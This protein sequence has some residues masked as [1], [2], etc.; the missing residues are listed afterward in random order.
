LKD[1]LSLP[2][3]PRG[4][5]QID[6]PNAFAES[7]CLRTAQ[8][9]VNSKARSPPALAQRPSLRATDAG[10][11]RWHGF[12]FLAVNRFRTSDIPQNAIEIHSASP[13]PK[14]L[15]T[16]LPGLDVAVLHVT[17]V[18]QFERLPG[19]AVVLRE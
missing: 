14:E 6:K 2:P 17:H 8:I 5:S 7:L 1:Q 4:G 19:H 15:G 3:D 9:Q 13:R 18:Q 12:S 10:W 11:S 16:F